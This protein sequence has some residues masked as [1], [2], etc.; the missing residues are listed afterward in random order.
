MTIEAFLPVGVD[1]HFHG[2]KELVLHRQGHGVGQT[3][4]DWLSVGGTRPNT[5]AAVT[6]PQVAPF[7]WGAEVVDEVAALPDEDRDVAALGRGKLLHG[8]RCHR[9]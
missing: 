6:D 5:H 4:R 7:G 3:L 8:R 1:E 2:L 9:C